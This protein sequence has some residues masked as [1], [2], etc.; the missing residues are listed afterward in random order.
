MINHPM[1]EI[2]IHILANMPFNKTLGLRLHTV[3]E[4]KITLDFS[5]HAGL[6]GNYVQGIL[7]GGVISSALDMA[8]GALVMFSLLDKHSLQNFEALALQL[9]KT[10]TVNLHIDYLRPGKGNDFVVTASIVRRGKK[11]TVTRMQLENE[12]RDLIAI[13]TGTYLIG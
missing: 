8:G 13:A 6:V 5:K 4:E 2:I 1:N 3:E 12:A 11:L 10:S 7:H 9:G